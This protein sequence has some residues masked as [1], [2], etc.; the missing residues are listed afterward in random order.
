[1]PC[2]V[3]PTLGFLAAACSGVPF[4]LAR[5]SVQGQTPDALFDALAVAFVQMISDASRYVV[6]G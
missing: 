2:A 1:M 3:R 5:L 4:N 6:S